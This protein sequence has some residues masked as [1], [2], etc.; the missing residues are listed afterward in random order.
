[1]VSYDNRSARDYFKTPAARLLGVDRR[2]TGKTHFL[3]SLNGKKF[4]FCYIRKNAC[5]AFKRLIVDS[6]PYKNECPATGNPINFM[7]RF[8]SE[9]SIINI[10]RCHYRIFV[11]RSPVERTASLFINKFVVRSGPEDIFKDFK[12]AT[13][14]DPQQATF[15]EFVTLYVARS[16]SLRDPHVWPQRD[17]LHNIVYTHAIF[18]EDLHDQAQI[19]FGDDIA[20]TYF[21]ERTNAS[22][23]NVDDS[24]SHLSRIAAEQLHIRWTMH[25]TI[26]AA[27]QLVTPALKSIISECYVSDTDLFE[28]LLRKRNA[29]KVAV[30][31]ET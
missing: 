31:R 30:L 3:F 12:L 29:R 9:N 19:L 5:S 23:G 24:V 10:S 11:Y 2:G 28:R 6:S 22:H 18:I 27:S 7:I 1:M 4:A 13:G 20:R 15:E 26:P 8:H 21:R 25:N 14:L 17:H 16:P